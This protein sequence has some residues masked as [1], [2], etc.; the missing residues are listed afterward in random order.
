[1]K[2]ELT[3]AREMRNRRLLLRK[4]TRRLSENVERI[5][6]R[7][8][9]SDLVCAF[10][11]EMEKMLK[12]LEKLYESA[13]VQTQNNRILAQAVLDLPEL[14]KDKTSRRKICARFRKLNPHMKL[15]WR[16]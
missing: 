6:D 8:V 11:E 13:Y 10:A 3:V 9:V 5:E 16:D 4:A 7:D 14:R 1:M 15:D 12:D 2:P